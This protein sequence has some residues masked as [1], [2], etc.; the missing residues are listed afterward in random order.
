MR[1][2]T[3]KAACSWLGIA[4]LLSVTCQRLAGAASNI[5]VGSTTIY[6]NETASVPVTIA[7]LDDLFVCH[8]SCESRILQPVL[9]QVTISGQALWLSNA[10]LADFESQSSFEMHIEATLQSNPADQKNI[11]V[12][13]WVVDLVEYP[14]ILPENAE[15]LANEN[16][17]AGSQI[18]DLRSITTETGRAMTSCQS[19]CV[20][21]ILQTNGSSGPITSPLALSSDGSLTIN[22][23]GKLD[24]ENVS[25]RQISILVQIESTISGVYRAA[26]ILLRVTDVAESPIYAR[27]SPLAASVLENQPAPVDVLQVF[28]YDPDTF[29]LTNHTNI[30]YTITS[31]GA[32]PFAISANGTIS[33]TAPLD[34]ESEGWHFLEIEASDG[35]AAAPAVMHVNITVLDATEDPIIFCEALNISENSAAGA[36]FTLFR[37]TDRDGQRGNRCERCTAQIT[38]IEPLLYN[39]LFQA[40]AALGSVQVSERASAVPGAQFSINRELPA[41]HRQRY[42]NVSI[43]EQIVFNVSLSGEQ[44]AEIWQACSAKLLD[45]N[46]PTVLLIG[47]AQ[48]Q[49][50][51]D[52]AKTAGELVSEFTYKAYD[53]D[54]HQS[55]QWE[56]TTIGTGGLRI[57]FDMLSPSIVN[58]SNTDPFSAQ[59]T[60]LQAASGLTPG[61]TSFYIQAVDPEQ[62]SLSSE[63]VVISLFVSDINDEPRLMESSTEFTV[64]E[65]A[66]IGGRI[67][68]LEAFDDDVMQGITFEI[69]GFYSSMFTVEKICQPAPTEPCNKTLH[70]P[71]DEPGENG[72]Y[73]RNSSFSRKAYLLVSSD[74]IDFDALDAIEVEVRLTDDGILKVSECFDYPLPGQT[75]SSI[76][77]IVVKIK[78]INDPPV[79]HSISIASPFGLTTAGGEPLQI[80]GSNLG[81]SLPFSEESS[82]Q[83]VINVWYSNAMKTL[84]ASDC[85]VVKNRVH[86]ECRSSPGSG[87][88]YRLVVAVG[89]GGSHWQISAQ[90][91]DELTYAAP[92]IARVVVDGRSFLGTKGNDSV[93]IQGTQFDTHDSG[94]LQ[95]VSYGPTGTEYNATN[96]VTSTDHQ[97][98]QCRTIGGVGTNL[99]WQVLIGGQVSSVPKTTYAAPQIMEAVIV[100]ASADGSFNR[101]NSMTD[102]ATGA[103]PFTFLWIKGNNFGPNIGRQ[104]IDFVQIGPCEGNSSTPDINF[105]NVCEMSPQS[106]LRA[107]GQC[108][109]LVSSLSI[110][111][112]DCAVT[113]P[114]SEIVCQMPEGVGR[115]LGVQIGLLGQESNVHW[116]YNTVSYALPSIDRI[117]T[118]LG[119]NLAPTLGTAATLEGDNFGPS[120]AQSERYLGISAATLRIVFSSSALSHQVSKINL[121]P[122]GGRRLQVAVEALC[123]KSAPIELDY[124]PP[125]ILSI[126]RKNGS[127]LEPPVHLTIRGVHFA[128][129][130]WAGVAGDKAFCASTNSSVVFEPASGQNTRCFVNTETLQDDFLEC[131]I[132]V[133]TQMNLEGNVRLTAAGQVDVAPFEYAALFEKPTIGPI[134]LISSSETDGLSLS[135]NIPSFVP[136]AADL[137]LKAF[138]VNSD[139]CTVEGRT[140]EVYATAPAGGATSF[141]VPNGQGT[142][143]IDLTYTGTQFRESIEYSYP[144][145]R[146]F[147]FGSSMK[148]S[149]GAFLLNNR[150]VNLHGLDVQMETLVTIQGENLGHPQYIPV[151]TRCGG[152]F[153]PL[154]DTD[155]NE[156]NKTHQLENN[157]T[158]GGEHCV[159]VSWG[160][161]EIKCLP[162]PGV[163]RQP[164]EVF[165]HKR[166]VGGSTGNVSKDSNAFIRLQAPQVYEY[167]IPT[168]LEAKYGGL[169]RN[170]ML[171]MDTVGP[172][173]GGTV[174]KLRGISFGTEKLCQHLSVEARVLLGGVS[175]RSGDADSGIIVHN[176]TEIWFTLP[177]SSGAGGSIAVEVD[178]ERTTSIDLLYDPPVIRA[179]EAVGEFV[180]GYQPEGTSST[181]GSVHV[182]VNFG[183]TNAGKQVGP[184]LLE[185]SKQDAIPFV[186]GS[187]AATDGILRFNARASFIRIHGENF[188]NA[189][190]PTVLFG[191]WRCDTVPGRSTIYVNSKLIECEIKD[192]PVGPKN[193]NLVVA[194]Y[195]VTYSEKNSKLY[196]ACSPGHFGSIT[197]FDLCLPCTPC[198][199]SDC[200]AQEGATQCAGGTE[201]PAAAAGHWLHGQ[202][203][204]RPVN[205][206]HIDEYD[207]VAVYDVTTQ[208]VLKTQMPSK[209]V[210]SAAQAHLLPSAA[211]FL[212]TPCMVPSGCLGNNTC[213][214]GY[215]GIACQ[216]CD[217]GFYRS[218]QDICV[219]CTESRASETFILFLTVGILLLT[220]GAYM[221]RFAPSTAGIAISVTSLQLLF[222][223]VQLNMS[224]SESSE[225]GG[226]LGGMLQLDFSLA[227]PKCSVG[228]DF[229]DQWYLYQMVPIL[230]LGVAMLIGAGLV[231]FNLFT[232]GT[233]G[234]G[235]AAQG[236]LGFLVT[237]LSLMYVGLISS[238]LEVLSCQEM[239]GK[240]VLTSNTEVDCFGNEYASIVWWAVISLAVYGCGIVLALGIAMR[241]YADVI[242]NNINLV[243][244]GRAHELLD[245]LSVS[246]R[247]LANKKRKLQVADTKGAVVHRLFSKLYRPYTEEHFN[248]GLVVFI[249]KFV[250]S[251]ISTYFRDDP[252]KSAQIL[253]IAL[254]GLTLYHAV[255]QPYTYQRLHLN[256]VSA[257]KAGALG[258]NLLTRL[259][260]HQKQLSAEQVV[261]GS[262]KHRVSVQNKMQTS[263]TSAWL[264]VGV[265]TSDQEA[266]NAEWLAEEQAAKA[267][268]APKRVARSVETPVGEPDSKDNPTIRGSLTVQP[269]AKATDAVK[270]DFA[271]QQQHRLKQNEFVE[272]WAAVDKR[273]ETSINPLRQE[274]VKRRILEEQKT[275][276]T[277]AVL[278]HK[279]NRRVSHMNDDEL[280]TWKAPMDTKHTADVQ[281]HFMPVQSSQE[282]S[283]LH[284][285]RRITALA[286]DE[287]S[288]LPSRKR[289]ATRVVTLA[290]K[291][292]S[293]AASHMNPMAKRA[294]A[295]NKSMKGSPKLQGMTKIHAGFGNRSVLAVS[296]AAAQEDTAATPRNDE[297]QAAK[298]IEAIEKDKAARIEKQEER[299]A[300]ALLKLTRFDDTWPR[301][302]FHFLLWHPDEA[303]VAAY[304]FRKATR[305]LLSRVFF[306]CCAGRRRRRS[307]PKPKASA[308][309]V[310]MFDSYPPVARPTLCSALAAIVAIWLR[311]S[312]G[313]VLT[314]SISHNLQAVALLALLL[315][316]TQGAILASTSATDLYLE[317]ASGGLIIALV[318]L[319]VAG[320][321][322]LAAVYCTWTHK[323]SQLFPPVAQAPA[324]LPDRVNQA[325]ALA[326]CGKP[327]HKKAHISLTTRRL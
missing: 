295:A 217:E 128:Q 99:V 55:T 109:A 291:S 111:L 315:F 22:P 311:T 232:V 259:N 96:C 113:V 307:H 209:Q 246:I 156:V 179:I 257:C 191:E 18:A 231:V 312:I 120:W 262:N 112:L 10:T 119:N 107:D 304:N 147:S 228:W 153:G 82:E 132:H 211:L 201:L 175:L 206:E 276:K 163:G 25:T 49:L 157:V 135:T 166:Q 213:A 8:P 169:P 46:E 140:R 184:F 124:A 43:I 9:S 267:A 256:L 297:E 54:V 243:Q 296:K 178:K 258:G 24:Y 80:Y 320:E 294:Q 50:Q 203:D 162:P 84:N 41:N 122:G 137:T 36:M 108:S 245:S 118:A 223:T 230:A 67:G 161:S 154:L 302:M 280:F 141:P 272:M 69:V 222:Q 110:R 221:M 293:P 13:V 28:A 288:S 106:N 224:W 273:L 283:P 62:P 87:F 322:L 220:G 275:V 316:A 81:H 195:N 35:T 318:A 229:F 219:A 100:Q 86:I 286:A 53:P 21:T 73:C 78:D 173:D 309:H 189:A 174:L 180:G 227:P 171:S 134:A 237:I 207:F 30:A 48:R 27:V 33:T 17:A 1:I 4:V 65:N 136:E 15:I 91:T 235:R 247:D 103:L 204:D 241:L 212:A 45:V 5:T 240:R 261:R 74:V 168:L 117:T 249:M 269:P 88:G 268:P 251:G 144:A 298:K 242:R 208:E 254:G 193:L 187:S 76:E 95:R 133:D 263:R 89:I 126:V 287:Y 265:I 314:L 83:Q 196:A 66:T 37:G 102:A 116:K 252:V 167:D 19:E 42:E 159:I 264:R 172:T 68:I 152:H 32:P 299:M 31:G 146:L 218:K 317:A 271:P 104:A 216:V 278:T 238:A 63:A 51:V 121:P 3:I 11:T 92:S 129:N 151:N 142:L 290:T 270:M 85:R 158:V 139:T 197:G 12:T 127:V 58:V 23:T 59:P 94:A 239:A 215:I 236:A 181:S 165:I 248:W 198:A 274:T 114:H 282:A 253:A 205:W 115:N 20:F 52:S 97:S 56:L 186:N 57:P 38:I 123:K 72:E 188:G 202:F 71:I 160:V 301:R 225:T 75:A 303:A 149:S 145:P 7:Q 77:T 26:T 190:S 98:I 155:G 148:P 281:R 305:H 323:A 200:S 185:P 289:G 47:Q 324:E 64:Q 143:L 138:L 130:C 255:Q 29:P 233:A 277:T 234:V 170:Y 101:T 260:V 266:I 306:R 285:G 326:R 93:I 292:S 210:A 14:T 310:V 321:V 44:G 319:S 183:Q 70:G 2:Y 79:I 176:H 194:G 61:L 308:V 90:S 327:A 199:T 60:Q 250:V 16:L 164:L 34:H 150:T 226:A 192:I 40:A 105:L 125:Q 244:S 313:S 325:L 279:R 300:Q 6:I 182:L 177:Q 284:R 214:P 39:D 131:S